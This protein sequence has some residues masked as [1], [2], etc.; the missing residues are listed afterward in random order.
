MKSRMNFQTT[1]I[2]AQIISG[3]RE[4]AVKGLKGLALTTLF[5][6]CMA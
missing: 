3:W 2:K 1:Q 6:L 5:L 4:T